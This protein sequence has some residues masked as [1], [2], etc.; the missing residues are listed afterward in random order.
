MTRGNGPVSDVTV[1]GDVTGGA[2]RE[3]RIDELAR[4]GETTV[5]NIR[6]YQDR[7]LLPPP[8]RAGRVGLY[9]P[10]HLARLRLIGQ[11]LR[12]GYGLSNIAELLG[13]WEGGQDLADLLGLEAALTEPWGEQS[14]VV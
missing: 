5:R 8:R 13:A 3:Y 6:A 14:P 11:L 9:G 4:L 10:A 12:R 1:G 7:G 2:A